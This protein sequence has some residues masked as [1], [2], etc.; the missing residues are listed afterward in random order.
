MRSSLSWLIKNIQDKKIASDNVIIYGA[1]A[2]AQLASIFKIENSY[3]LISFIDDD[4]S[5][6]EDQFILFK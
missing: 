1:G 3:N 6:W 4:K 2:G 5:L